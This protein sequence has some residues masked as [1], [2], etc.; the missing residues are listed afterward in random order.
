MKTL[1]ILG[2]AV[3]LLVLAGPAGAQ[4]RTV[5]QTMDYHN[6]VTFV[7][8]PF[9][10]SPLD[11]EVHLDSSP[12]YRTNIEDWNWTHNLTAVRPAA[13]LGIQ[14]AT[15]TI[16]AWDVGSLAE[17][18]DH[19]IY[20]G[21]DTYYSDVFNA[22]LYDRTGVQLG[23]LKSF[24]EANVTVPWPSTGQRADY[25]TRFSRTT[26]NIPEAALDTLWN[27]NEL[28]FWIDID[29]SD[30]NG[31]KVTLI[32]STLAV[33]YIIPSPPA[34]TLPV[35]RFWSPTLPGIPH[36][37]TIDEAEKQYVVDNYPNDWTY[38]GVAYNALPVDTNN[39]DARPVYRFWSAPL[40]GHFY[41]MDETEKNYVMETLSDWWTF[42]GAVFAAFP[43]SNHP[44]DTYPVHRFWSESLGHHFYT[45]DEAEKQYVIEHYPDVWT[46]EGVAWYAYVP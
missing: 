19:V 21:G 8:P 37:Y 34:G 6:N 7:I 44:D 23:V 15:L 42:E 35:Y 33:E 41:T 18:E 9:F 2:W 14:A 28:T 25:A 24:Y 43:E 26:F 11:P 46:Y 38:E 3:G 13:A 22:W 40:G 12:Y 1:R 31:N 17:G 39:I 29:Q 5:V 27:D 36:F 10:A 45:M 32:D 4:I 20:I 16:T 30:P